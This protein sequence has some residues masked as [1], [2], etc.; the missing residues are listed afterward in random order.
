ML[1]DSALR[2]DHDSSDMNTHN[3]LDQYHHS[4]RFWMEFQDGKRYM[5]AIAGR[6]YDSRGN[7]I[8]AIE[9]IRDMTDMKKANDALVISNK[10][11]NL[12]LPDLKT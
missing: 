3:E 12:L 10:K 1:I 4:A 2:N 5:S 6:I 9:T 11:L 8:G 7:I